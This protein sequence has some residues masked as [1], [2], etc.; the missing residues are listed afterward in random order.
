MQRVE[1]RLGL[2]AGWCDIDGDPRHDLD[3]VGRPPALSR[4]LSDLA[5]ELLGG[6]QVGLGGEHHVGDPR[7][8]LDRRVGSAGLNDDR[9]ALRGAGGVQRTL[10]GEVLALVIEDPDLRRIEEPACLLVVKQR[11]GIEPVPK[12]HHH[13]G[14][15]IGPLISVGIGVVAFQVEVERFLLLAAG[16]T[17]PARAPAADMIQRGEHARHGIGFGIAGGAGRGEAD[18]PFVARQRR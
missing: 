5:A 10:D 15:F 11:V 17:V 12:P 8:H 6:G 2:L 13:I 14:E 1:L 4:R 7:G 18:M 16:D 3:I 9:P